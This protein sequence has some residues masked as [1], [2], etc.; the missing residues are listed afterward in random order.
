MKT[1][2]RFIAFC[3][4]MAFY[5]PVADASNWPVLPDKDGLAMIPAQQWKFKPGPREVKVFVHYPGGRRENVKAKTGLMLSLHNWGGTGFIGTADP[6]TL[7]DRYNVVVIGV[8]YLQSGRDWQKS[9]GPYDFGYLQALD[10]I[11]ALYWVY[12]GLEKLKIP[13]DAGRIYAVGGSGGGNVTLMS[14]KLA[15]RTFACSIDISGM[16]KLSDDF[17]FG[18]PG[19]TKLD[20]GYSR[21]PQKPN[22]LSPDDQTIRCPG[23]LGHLK[24]MKAL[25]NSSKIIVIHGVDDASCPV[26]DAREMVANMKT[27]D[28]DVEPHFVTKAD[29]NGKLFKNTGHSLADRTKVALHF[30]DEFILSTS[31][32]MKVRPGKCDFLCRDEKV[33]FETPN[34]RFVISYTKGYPVGRFEAS[35]SAVQKKR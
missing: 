25:G 2:F 32:K 21:D 15:P 8:N 11:R 27:A 34:G 5:A 4:T 17:A 29:V 10:A 19:G 16:A 12:E 7:A 9:G 6:R 33:Q 18:L 26:S 31:P 28:L 20:A 22:Y 30:G 24:T 14:N 1:T 23:E 35:V 13:F 3:I